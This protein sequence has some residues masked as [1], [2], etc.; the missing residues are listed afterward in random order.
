[1]MCIFSFGR[2]VS[3]ELNC[4][5][6]TVCIDQMADLHSAHSNTSK[7]RMKKGTSELTL[8]QISQAEYSAVVLYEIVS[9]FR[10]L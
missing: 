1:M 7:V 4:Q 2:F 6:T 8:S 5:V 9:H 10:M 3:A